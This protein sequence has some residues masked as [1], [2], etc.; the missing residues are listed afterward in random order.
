MAASQL[1]AWPRFMWNWTFCAAATTIVSGAVAERATFF[2]YLCYSTYISTFVYPVVVHWM[3]SSDGWL[4]PRNSSRLLGIG[5][6]DFAGDCAPSFLPPPLLLPQNSPSYFVLPAQTAPWQFERGRH[7]LQHSTAARC[8]PSA[9][10]CRPLLAGRSPTLRVLSQQPR[11]CMSPSPG[12][13]LPSDTGGPK[14]LLLR[15]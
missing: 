14:V 1:P 5:A 7:A 3:W 11:L 9:A 15:T 8:G 10:A 4:S 13:S 6:V 12:L 2:S